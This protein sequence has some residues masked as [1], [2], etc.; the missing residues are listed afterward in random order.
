MTRN[1]SAG[2]A[3][4]NASEA[5]TGRPAAAGT[6]VVGRERELLLIR[7]VLEA[8][9]D[10]VLEGPPGVS[11]TT[12]LSAVT[13]E[14]GVP[15]HLVEG[16]GDLTPSKLMGH[17][18]PARVLREGYTEENFVPGP[19]VH[20]MQQG[21]FLYFEELNRAPEDTLNA[22]LMAMSDRSIEV[23]RYGR[24]EALAG[25]R[26]VASMNPFDNVGTRR[27][28]ASV[29]DRFNRLVIS[30]QDMAEECGIVRLRVEETTPFLD[31]VVADAVAVTRAT[32][33]H[34]AVQQGSSVRGAID[35]ASITSR[36]LRQRE[37]RS[38]DDTGYRDAFLD[39]MLLSLSGRIHT[40][41]SSLRTAE[42]VLREI[43]EDRFL[44]AKAT[45]APG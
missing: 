24:V 20:A 33:K 7:A 38:T 42:D 1:A 12:M 3:A 41:V 23:P 36:I 15:L 16:N 28:S 43:W 34:H 13:A 29:H 10:L 27:L 8:G 25:F 4:G 9:R 14:W 30:Y 39:A 26:I 45:T 32:R 22:L 2:R 17:H 5:Q 11:K 37:V 44:L 21:G 6:S 18:S 35:C 40:S 31:D 19:L